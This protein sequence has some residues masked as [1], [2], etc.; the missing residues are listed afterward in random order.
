MKSIFVALLGVGQPEVQ[1]AAAR[2]DLLEEL[3]DRVLVAVGEARDGA[4]YLASD[5]ARR[6]AQPTGA[7]R[8][9]AR[10]KT[11]CAGRCRR[12]PDGPGRSARA[13][14][15]SARRASS[16]AAAADRPRVSS[17]ARG[18]ALRHSRIRRSMYSSFRC[19]RPAGVARRPVGARVEPDGERLREIFVGMALRVPVIEMLDEA[20]AVRLRR[21][22]LG[23]RRRRAAEQPAPRRPPAQVVRVVDRVAGFVAQDLQARRSIAAFDFEH[24]RQLELLQPRMREVEG[25]RDARD[26]VRREPLVRQPVVRPERRPRLT[27]SAFTVAMRCSSSGALQS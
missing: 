4:P 2:D 23:I 20:L 12:S 3:V 10:R 14:C 18:R 11:G 7:W 26:A 16:A 27:S 22:V 21:V 1:L 13:S 6:S 17:S 24:L 15:G 25:D 5:R 9:P 8:T 19:G